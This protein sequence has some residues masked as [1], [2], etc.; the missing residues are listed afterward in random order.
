LQSKARGDG[1]RAGREDWSYRLRGGFFC[2]GIADGE[3][4]VADHAPAHPT[5]HAVVALVS[6]SVEAVAALDHADAPLGSGPPLLPVAEPALLLFA[7][8]LGALGGA[9]GN[10][11]PLDAFGLRGSLV[12]A[13]VKGRIRR[14]QVRR[15]S[16]PGLMALDCRDQ[17]VG[18]VGP[19][20]ID[21]V[22]G[23]NLVLG[24]LQL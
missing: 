10:A 15:P 2:H 16:K 19:P 4:I 22:V 23:D 20:I 11:N 8:A 5:P 14:H 3:E 17:Q 13:R 18:I 24:L 6:A 1:R 7:F 21:F 9:I 12:L